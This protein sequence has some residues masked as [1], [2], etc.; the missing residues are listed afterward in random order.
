MNLSLGARVRNCFIIANIV[1]IVLGFIIF[2]FLNSLNKDIE[3]ISLKSNRASLLTDEIR[4]SAVSILKY[5]R[6]ILTKT[7]KPEELARVIELCD[8][9]ASQLNTLDSFYKDADTKKIVAQML[10]YVDSLKL[11]LSKASLYRRDQVGVSTIGD[12]ADKILDAFTEFQDIQ[13]YQNVKR[14]EQIKKIINETK[15][16]MMIVLIVSFL[17]TIILALV[18]PGKIALPFKKI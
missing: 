15:R 13:Y 10:G 7:P 2:Q 14:D 8:S 16:H 3:E 18:V 4:I 12:L 11:V 6:K 5:Q 9:F 1:V 17:F